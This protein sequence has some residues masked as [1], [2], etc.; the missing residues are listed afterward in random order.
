MCD[1]PG[2]LYFA[3]IKKLRESLRQYMPDGALHVQV[4]MKVHLD[5][6]LLQLYASASA[7]AASVLGARPALPLQT[8]PPA[9]AVAVTRRPGSEDQLEQPSGNDGHGVSDVAASEVR[10]VPARCGRIYHAA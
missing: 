6:D 4:R 3:R 7:A 5:A 10:N 2:M 8:L 1:P 9:A